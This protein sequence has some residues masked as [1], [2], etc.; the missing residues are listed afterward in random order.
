MCT[1]P[2]ALL[3]AAPVAAGRAHPLPPTRELWSGQA[4]TL[5]CVAIH[6]APVAGDQLPEWDTA[7]L[8]IAGVGA[9]GTALRRGAAGSQRACS[10]RVWY[11]RFEPW[12]KRWRKARRERHLYGGRRSATRKS[13]R[14]PI[15]SDGGICTRMSNLTIVSRR[16]TIRNCFF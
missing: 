16:G 15:G 2:S 10:S 14:S 7:P 3:A 9:D 5:P 6:V 4:V 8:E 1:A 11:I 12:R 13:R